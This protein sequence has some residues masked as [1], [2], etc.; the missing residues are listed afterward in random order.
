MFTKRS[1]NPDMDDALRPDSVT[2]LTMARATHEAQS[3]SRHRV[4]MLAE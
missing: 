1:C 2:Q 3:L 4:L